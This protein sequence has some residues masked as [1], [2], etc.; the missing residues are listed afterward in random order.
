MSQNETP[1]G[2]RDV[3]N[4]WRPVVFEQRADHLVR[5]ADMVKSLRAFFDR[6][7]YVEVETPALQLSP[8]MEPHL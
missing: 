5:R 6:N 2:G 4:W 7:G 3:E 1:Q 8:G